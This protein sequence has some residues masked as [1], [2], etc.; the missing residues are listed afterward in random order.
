MKAISL[1]QVNGRHSGSPTASISLIVLLDSLLPEAAHVRKAV[2]A[3]ANVNQ[4]VAIVVVWFEGVR[5]LIGSP[6]VDWASA[7]FRT[8]PT[9]ELTRTLRFVVERRAK[10][11]D[12]GDLVE[13]V[14]RK[15]HGKVCCKRPCRVPAGPC[16]R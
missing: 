6:P 3:E 2:L 15:H 14:S 4:K 7:R 16:A 5:D 8:I 13:A 1:S 12:A 11:D 10:R 9:A